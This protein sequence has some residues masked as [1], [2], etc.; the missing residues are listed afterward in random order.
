MTTT[1]QGSSVVLTVQFFEYESGPAQDVTDLTITITAPDSSVD[2]PTTSAGITHVTTGTYQYTWAVSA[3]AVLGDHVV[4]WVANEASA[5]ELVTVT[6]L[7]PSGSANEVW[8]CVR[9]E[10]K[11]ALDVAATSR[12][13]DQIDTEIASSSR[14]IEGELL[15]YFYP[16]YSVQTF[17]WPDHQYSAPWRLWL[18]QRE[19][20]GVPTQVLSGGIDITSAVLMRPDDAPM[21]SRP[22]TKIEI[23]LAGSEAFSSGNT[24]QR[25][26]SVTG[27]FGFTAA[28]QSAGTVP[29]GGIDASTSINL[30]V[31][32]YRGVGSILLIDAERIIITERSSVSTAQ[33]LGSGG[34]AASNAGTAV[35]VADITQ[36]AIGETITIDAESMLIQNATGTNLIVKRAW[37]G[38]VLAAHSVGA[39]IYADR[40]LTVQRGALGT[41]A[42]THA[43]GATIA[44]HNPPSLIRKL[45]IAQ[46]IAGLIQTKAGYPSPTGKKS[47]RGAT[48]DPSQTPVSD[49]SDL[50]DRATDAYARM[51][52]R[53]PAR[54][55]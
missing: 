25:S 43:A 54:L 31:P 45:C 35:P 38:S 2:V 8:Y 13:D 44:E 39:T 17:D 15:R 47:P 42:T 20:C 4:S 27:L 51:R 53:T 11:A 50:W 37:D 55:V 41:T 36:F 40:Q 30:G 34:L 24:F 32:A 26:I 12:N 16:N 22:F 5:S 49:L 21:R 52:T 29:A 46:A 7:V 48:G 1:A 10:V 33:A 14:M 3:E 19:M 18:D 23:N 28:S 6:A 9:E